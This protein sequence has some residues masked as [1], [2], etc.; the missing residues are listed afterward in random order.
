MKHDFSILTFC[1][2]PTYISGYEVQ[3]RINGQRKT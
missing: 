3:N 2:Q 1:P